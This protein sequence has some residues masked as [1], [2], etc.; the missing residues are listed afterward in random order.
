MNKQYL[1]RSLCGV[2]IIMAVV[3]LSEHMQVE[4]FAN[5]PQVHTAWIGALISG[6]AS[7][8]GGIAGTV[9]KN[10]AAQRKERM[11]DKQQEKLD[12]WY[13][14]EMNTSYVDRADSQDLLRRI[15]E[16]NKEAMKSLNTDA[17]KSG[18][19]EEA[20]VAAASRQNRNYADAVGR[21]AAM[22]Q[23]H[24]DNVSQQYMTNTNSIEQARMGLQGDGG[25]DALAGGISGAGG[26][27]GSIVEDILGE[28]NKAS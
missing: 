26:T 8:A 25:G 7:L 17:I 24:K 3:Y 16:Q 20:K 10:N 18:A 1:L 12:D 27:I 14:T 19:T 11:L 13:E 22:G 9:A 21:I 5:S 28:K 2:F 6:V 15:T 23:R 4:A